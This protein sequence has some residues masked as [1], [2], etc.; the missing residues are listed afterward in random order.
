LICKIYFSSLKNKPKWT[1]QIKENELQMN[2]GRVEIEF[3]FFRPFTRDR[4]VLI[5]CDDALIL[6]QILG[7]DFGFE[8][9][10]DEKFITKKRMN[11]G[12]F[13]VL[14]ERVL[15]FLCDSMGFDIH[16]RNGSKVVLQK[17]YEK[18]EQIL[19]LVMTEIRLQ[20]DFGGFLSGNVRENIE[21]DEN[22]R[23]IAKEIADS[24]DV[25]S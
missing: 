1:L 23:S 19:R 2:S 20:G 14:K 15:Q 18:E 21:N 12:E 17:H 7:G 16:S 3:V 13:E 10:A 25:K 5:R 9:C 22:L 11:W 4:S 8:K 24:L 6:N